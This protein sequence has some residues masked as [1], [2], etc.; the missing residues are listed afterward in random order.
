MIRVNKIEAVSS[1]YFGY[2][3]GYGGIIWC[4]FYRE[5]KE[6]FGVRGSWSFCRFYVDFGGF[7]FVIRG[8]MV[9]GFV[10]VFREVAFS[11]NEFTWR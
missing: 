2:G 3:D 5:F 11:V 7:N 8:F 6:K 9:S 4:F 10:R 1:V